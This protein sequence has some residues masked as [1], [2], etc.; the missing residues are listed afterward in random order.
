[1]QKQVLKQAILENSYAILTSEGISAIRMRELAKSCHCAVGTIYNVFETF[2]E[3]HFHLNLRTFKNLIEKLIQSLKEAIEQKLSMEELLPKV[4]WEYISFAKNE[5]NSW[6]ALFEYAPKKEPPPWYGQE[7]DRY[8]QIVEGILK[9]NF[10]I[11]EEKANQLI[12][13]FWFAIHGVSSIVLNKK[14]TNHSDEFVE[15]YVDHCL[16]GIYKLI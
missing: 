16:H 13:Y 10:H 3:I 5:T 15:S 7:I 1:M 8:I 2:E 11:S 9:E 12:N 6:K 14:A 4:G